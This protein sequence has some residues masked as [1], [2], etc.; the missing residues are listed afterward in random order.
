MVIQGALA[1]LVMT[2]AGV[3]V[4]SIFLMFAM[5]MKGD[6]YIEGRTIVTTIIGTFLVVG[7][8][9]FSMLMITGQTIR[10]S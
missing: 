3:G 1:A 5:I 6:S 8:F 7:V 2:L 9:A 4:A 10:L